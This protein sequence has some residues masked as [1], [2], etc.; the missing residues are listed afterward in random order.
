MYFSLRSLNST[1]E[2]LI[3]L[4]KSKERFG[5]NKLYWIIHYE[6]IQC[7]LPCLFNI[8]LQPIIKHHPTKFI[9]KRSKYNHSNYLGCED[10]VYSIQ[11]PK[12]GLYFFTTLNFIKFQ[13]FKSSL[14]HSSVLWKQLLTKC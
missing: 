14:T 3:S 1:S 12:K 2:S 4:I 10:F 8:Y 6:N 13:F 11:F 7:V 5:K 9:G